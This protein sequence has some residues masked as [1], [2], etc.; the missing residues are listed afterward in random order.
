MGG[1]ISYDLFASSSIAQRSFASSFFLI[2]VSIL[3]AL[4]KFE[5]LS[6]SFPPTSLNSINLDRSAPLKYL[7]LLS[8]AWLTMQIS[9]PGR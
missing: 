5:G 3:F 1:S 8:A 6:T 7:S 4:G 2:T 9:L